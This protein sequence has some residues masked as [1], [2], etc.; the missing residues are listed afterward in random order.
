MSGVEILKLNYTKWGFLPIQNNIFK[1]SFALVKATGSSQK[2]V[3][4]N[5]IYDNTNNERNVMLQNIYQ[6]YTKEW[7]FRNKQQKLIQ[8]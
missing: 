3:K 4:I 1:I 5:E 6:G 2:Y 7:N 8:R